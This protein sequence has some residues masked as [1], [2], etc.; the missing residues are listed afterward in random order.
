MFRNFKTKIDMIGVLPALFIVGF[1]GH[2]ISFTEPFMIDLTKYFLYIVNFY[3]IYQ[4]LLSNDK[5][6][7]IWIFIT[8]LYTFNL[9]VIGVKTGL[10]FGDYSYGSTLGF[11]LFEVPL[12]IGVN[13]LLVVLGAITLVSKYIKNKVCI[14]LFVPILTVIFDIFLEPVAVKYDYWNWTGGMIPLQNYIAWFLISLISVIFY[15]LIKPKSMVEKLD[16]YFICQIAFF[17]LLALF[18]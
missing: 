16:L 2:F 15:I 18:K 5:R 12:I 9:E 3:F 11:K 6:L 7:L 10:I 17:G 8:F 14:V 4:I 1:L 13:W